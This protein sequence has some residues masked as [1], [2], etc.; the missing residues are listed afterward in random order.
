MLESGISY[1]DVG[2]DPK[3]QDW[4]RYSVD[5]KGNVKTPDGL[6]Y[7][8]GDGQDFIQ[9][10]NGVGRD[11]FIRQKDGGLIPF[12]KWQIN[13][14]K[15]NFGLEQHP[16][17]GKINR[18]QL[19]RIIEEAKKPGAQLGKTFDLKKE[20]SVQ[21][22]YAA[23]MAEDI[24]EQI[25]KD[26][27]WQT[28]EKIIE[29]EK[30]KGVIMSFKFP[31]EWLV[32]GIKKDDFKVSINAKN[33]Q[34]VISVPPDLYLAYVCNE[35]V[36]EIKS[37]MDIVFNQGRKP[38]LMEETLGKG[39]LYIGQLVREYKEKVEHQSLKLK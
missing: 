24:V 36:R 3:D 4:R 21:I 19:I 34:T 1:E 22:G 25:K 26:P 2:L 5:G 35:A 8:L 31:P 20:D 18:D 16:L 27:R 17:S 32:S 30:N 11:S 9:I 7:K 38:L 15:N 6:F 37:K 13:Y 33:N 29:T 10:E 23:E 14:W 28:M 39:L 12:S